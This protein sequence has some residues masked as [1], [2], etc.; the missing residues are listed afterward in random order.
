MADRP[1]LISGERDDIRWLWHSALS[2]QGGMPKLSMIAG[3]GK[4]VAQGSYTPRG[5]AER[6]RK[7]HVVTGSLPH[8]RLEN[9]AVSRWF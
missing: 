5:E 7:A 9:T 8:V 4:M 3:G 1:A 2:V 6:P